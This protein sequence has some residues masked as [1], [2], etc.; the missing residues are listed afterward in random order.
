MLAKFWSLL[1]SSVV[2]LPGAILCVFLM[3][4]GLYTLYPIVFLSG[5]ALGVLAL[6]C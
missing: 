3:Q 6:F 1:C 2:L 4:H 5:C